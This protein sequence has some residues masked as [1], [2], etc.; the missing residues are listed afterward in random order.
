MRNNDSGSCATESFTNRSAA[1]RGNS[2][3]TGINSIIAP[4]LFATFTTRYCFINFI[5][6]Y[7]R[8]RFPSSPI[9]PKINVSLRRI[10]S[11]HRG[12]RDA[13]RKNKVRNLESKLKQSSGLPLGPPCPPWL[14]SLPYFFGSTSTY[15]ASMTPSSFFCSWPDGAAPLLSAPAPPPPGKPPACAPPEG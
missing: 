11:H 1:S 2:P 5:T 8:F 13:Q 6:G 7:S 12:H 15:S 4:S 10:D 14:L 9:N 3:A